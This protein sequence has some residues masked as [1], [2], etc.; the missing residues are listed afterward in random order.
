MSNSTRTYQSRIQESFVEALPIYASLMSLVEHKLFAEICRGK[1]A[2][3]LKSSYLIRYG[4]TARQFNAI[5]VKIEGK[6]DSITQRRKQLIEEKKHQIEALESTP[7]EKTKAIHLTISDKKT[8]NRS[9]NNPSLL[10]L[11]KS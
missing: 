10:V 11:R 3:G 9:R 5:R 1:E 4:I 8:S 2:G 6:I 7:S